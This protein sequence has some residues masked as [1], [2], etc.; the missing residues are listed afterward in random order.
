MSTGRLGSSAFQ[1]TNCCHGHRVD[2]Q[3]S[4]TYRRP[5]PSVLASL[6]QNSLPGPARSWFSSIYGRHMVKAVRLIRRKVLEPQCWRKNTRCNS[7]AVVTG[8]EAYRP[9]FCRAR[10][11]ETSSTTDIKVIRSPLNNQIINRIN[12]LFYSLID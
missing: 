9:K 12:L 4:A 3:S 11:R 5:R 10:I 1:K 7:V 2:L 6:Y 8:A